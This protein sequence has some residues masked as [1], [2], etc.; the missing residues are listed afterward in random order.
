LVFK[1]ETKYS[2]LTSRPGERRSRKRKKRR[3]RKRME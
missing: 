3:K 1:V 2:Q